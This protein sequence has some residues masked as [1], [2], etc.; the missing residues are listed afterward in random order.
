MADPADVE[1]LE[2]RAA[3][4]GTMAV[5]RALPRRQRRTV[6]AWCFVDYSARLR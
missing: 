3:T 4:V 6:G 1:V 5:Q 2:P